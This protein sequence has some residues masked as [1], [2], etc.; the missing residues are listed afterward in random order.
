MGEFTRTGAAPRGYLDVAHALAAGGDAVW[1]RR[2]LD[3]A[4][5]RLD[6][7]DHRL[8]VV[9][10]LVLAGG[11]VLPPDLRA[12]IDATLTTFKYWMD[13]PGSDSMCQWS[14]SHY[15][16]FATCEYFAGHLLPDASFRN[17]GRSGA[18]KKARGAARLNGW[19]GDRFRWGFSEWLS[20]SYYAVNASALALLADYADEPLATRAS[21]VLDVLMLDLAM[22]RIDGRFVASAGRAYTT[23]KTNPARAEINDVLASAFGTRP[24]LRPD[25]YTG[26]FID[27]ER[28][29]VP[30]SIREIAASSGGH[31]IK[32]STGLDLPEV[33]PQVALHHS[34][35]GITGLHEALLRQYW[36]AE[37]FASAEAIP[38]T[39]RA[40]R[41]YKL[42]TNRFLAPLEPFAKLPSLALP[43]LVRSMNPMHAWAAL[44]R[45]NVQTRRTPEYLLSS[46]QHYQP[47]GFGDQQSLWTAALP[48]DVTVFGTHP[49][50]TALSGESRPATPSAWVGNGINPDTAQFGNVLLVLHDLRVRRGYLEGRRHE[51]SH[52]YF[53][54]VKFDET[55]V[56]HHVVAGRVDD[57]YLGVVSLLPLDL[58]SEAEL[59]QRGEV[60]AYAVIMADRSDYGSLGRFVDALKGHHLRYTRGTLSFQNGAH[61]FALS[62]KGGFTVDGRSV[63]GDYQRYDTDWV[64]A[65]R[66]PE[67]LEVAGRGHVL[68]LD[69][70]AGTRTEYTS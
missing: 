18:R 67:R 37:A 42:A 9:L 44:Q 31:T 56:G 48:G 64:S 11:D 12:D 60:T 4:D 66:N 41:E 20:S 39:V 38:T 68:E 27:R 52:L 5:A 63:S 53:P 16:A 24:P 62:P 23:Q 61:R 46:V 25:H 50:S 45:A 49:G 35:E 17:D 40:F 33:G 58:A 6:L 19:L 1:L 22:H 54:L 28:Y 15:L 3:F 57:S 55:R 8:L 13:E 70:A 2:M 10:K 65:P 21:M 30:D 43:T 36:G 59:V 47:G 29:R 7:S 34:S 32:T 69:W 14:E 26:V 51:L